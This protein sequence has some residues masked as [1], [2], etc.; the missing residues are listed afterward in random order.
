MLILIALAVTTLAEKPIP[1]IQDTSQSAP[2]EAE[3]LRG[4][5]LVDYVNQHQTLWKAEYSPGVEA[6]FKYYDGRKVEE[7]SSKAV[8]D[9]KRIRDIVLDVE[10]PESFDARDHWPNCPSIPY[11]RDQSN[12]VGAYAVAPAS[13]FSDR[14]CIQ[15]NGTI[16][17]GIT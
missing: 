14:A 9:P 4:E 5:A 11:I 2:K 16:K 7:K 10:P 12:C 8:H 3:Q 17:A 1:I 6:Y 15:S 13:A